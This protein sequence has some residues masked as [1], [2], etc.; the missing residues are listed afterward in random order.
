MPPLRLLSSMLQ[1]RECDP[2]NAWTQTVTAKVL[3]IG[4]LVLLMIVAQMMY[5]TRCI[6]WH[7]YVPMTSE[8]AMP[9]PAPPAAIMV[10]P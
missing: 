1:S 3:G 9:P 8:P 4:V 7:V 2:M 6:E 10:Q 5:L